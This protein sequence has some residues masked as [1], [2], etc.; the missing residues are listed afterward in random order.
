MTRIQKLHHV[1]AIEKEVKG[2]SYTAFNELNKKSTKPD[3]FNGHSKGYKPVKEDGEVLPPDSKIV[4]MT[5]SQQLTQAQEILSSLFDMTA[6]KDF[7]NCSAKADLVIP[8]GPTLISGAPS[9]LLLFLEKQLRDLRAFVSGLPTLDGNE[10]WTF[11]NNSGIY[12]SDETKTHRTKKN[13][14]PIVL[15]GATDKHPAQTQLIT[16]DELVGYWET[17]KQSGCMPSTR[18]KVLLDRID[19]LSAAVKQARQDANSNEAPE[20]KIGN[21]ILGYIFAD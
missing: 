14:K 18:Q 15:Y 2:K 17:I 5:V 12:K 10:Q 6:T 11:D 21:A 8:N 19:I 16:E 7:A 3:L 1:I 4:Q 13:Q 20:K 9:T